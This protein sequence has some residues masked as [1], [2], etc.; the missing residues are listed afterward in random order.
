VEEYK[1]INK[2]EKLIF[3]SSTWKT[4]YH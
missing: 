1:T 4:C 3:I 2:Y